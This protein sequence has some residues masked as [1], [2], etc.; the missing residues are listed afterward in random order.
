MVAREGKRR[1]EGGRRSGEGKVNEWMDGWSRPVSG[2]Q[3]QSPWPLL[4]AAFLTVQLTADP[5]C[6]VPAS[7]GAVSS[8]GRGNASGERSRWSFKAIA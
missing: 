3:S 7:T 4:F 5:Q 6:A 8:D 2:G 1:E